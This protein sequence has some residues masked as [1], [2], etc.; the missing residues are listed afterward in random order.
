[1]SGSLYAQQQTKELSGFMQQGTGTCTVFVHST[2]TQCP[3][4]PKQQGNG[5]LQPPTKPEQPSC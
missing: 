2:I 3:L 1:M 5:S 4:F